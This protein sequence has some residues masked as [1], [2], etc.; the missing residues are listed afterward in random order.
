MV[1][2]WSSWLWTALARSRSTTF[3]TQ[4]PPASP[5]TKAFWAPLGMRLSVNPAAVDCYLHHLGVTT[6]HSTYRAVT[7]LQPAHY[8]V[9]T[10]H[11]S[12]AVNYWKPNFADKIAVSEAEALERVD[13]ALDCAVRRRLSD[14]PPVDRCQLCASPSLGAVQPSCM[15]SSES[16]A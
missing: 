15:V 9:F 5:L 4:N 6:D 10:R 7:R 14:I 3:T 12:K 16:R 11:G 1:C 8:A 13:A 2:Q